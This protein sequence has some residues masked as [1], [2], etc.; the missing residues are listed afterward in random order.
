[1]ANSKQIVG[2]WALIKFRQIT[3]SQLNF[4]IENIYGE[5]FE[6]AN[7]KIKTCLAVFKLIVNCFCDSRSFLFCIV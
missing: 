5:Q 1:M 6:M 7:M 3:K 4:E 2:L